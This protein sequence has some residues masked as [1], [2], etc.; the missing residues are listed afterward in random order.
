MASLYDTSA[1]SSLNEDKYINKLYDSTLDSHKKA[2][3][4]E[5]V[6]T[7]QKIFSDSVISQP[8][9]QIQLQTEE[10]RQKEH[11]RNPDPLFKILLESFKK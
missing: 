5:I 11:H 6:G 9:Y 8:R 10:G 3:Q 4:Q 2:V 1:N 7:L